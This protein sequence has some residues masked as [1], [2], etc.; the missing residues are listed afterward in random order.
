MGWGDFQQLAD[1]MAS[2]NG[3]W[4]T[5]VEGVDGVQATA[6]NFSSVASPPRA[7]RIREFDA[8]DENIYT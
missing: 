6:I 5:T 3:L 7:K 2:E 4:L 1:D 8:L